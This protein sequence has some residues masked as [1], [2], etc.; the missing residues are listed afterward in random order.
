MPSPRVQQQIDRLLDEAEQAMADTD[1][2][3]VRKRCEAAL[4]LDP[5]NEDAQFYIDAADRAEGKSPAPT[6]DEQVTAAPSSPAERTTADASEIT[7]FADG[8]YEVT[9]FL[10]EGGRKIVYLAKDTLLDR[11]VA[12]ALI[13]TEGLDDAARERITREAQTM[14]RLGTHPNVVSVLDIG[15]HEGQPFV[16]IELLGGGDVEGL[17]E[18]AAG[19]LPLERTLEIAKDSARG[20]DFIHSKSIVHRDMKPGN[21]WLTADGVAKIGDYGLALSGNRTRLTLEGTMV[22]TVD[23]MPP[24]Q[25]LGGEITPRSDLYS[26]GAMIYELVTGTVPFKGDRITEVISQH[27]NT[28]PELPSLRGAKIPPALEELIL[29]LMAK[30]PDD[31]PESAAEVLQL[32]DTIDPSDTSQLDADYLAQ[33]AQGVFVGRSRELAEL[34]QRFDEA[35]SGISRLV[36]LVG[37]PGIGKTRLARELETH[38]RMR[39][40]RIYWGRAPEG[41]GAPPYWLFHQLL[42]GFLDANDELAARRDLGEEAPV[43]ARI[44]PDIATQL[45]GVSVDESAN[46]FA[47]HEA[48]RTFLNRLSRGTAL[49]VVLDDLH[50]AD[51]ES[52]AVLQHIS[53]DLEPTPLMFLGTYRDTET[54]RGDPLFEALATFNRE[55]SFVRL[56]VRGLDREG[57]AEFIERSAGFEPTREQLDL[58]IRETDGNPFFLSETVRSMLDAGTLDERAYELVTPD[59]VREALARRVNELDHDAVELLKLAAIVGYE[60]D[61]STLSIIS[62]FDEDRQLQLI[63]NALAERVIAEGESAGTYRFVY[64]PMQRLLLDEMAATRR[65]RLHG[66]IADRLAESYGSQADAHATVL[67]LHNAAAAEL[68][69]ERLDMALHFSEIA[70][71]QAESHND[72]LEAE[73]L[74]SRVLVLLERHSSSDDPRRATALSSLGRVEMRLGISFGDAKKH[75]SQAIDGFSA[76]RDVDSLVRAALDAF[77]LGNPRQTV[78]L[79][80]R[81]LRA[82]E[83]G[84]PVG[85]ARLL[86]W[87]AAGHGAGP[88]GNAAAERAETLA[89]QLDLPDVKGVLAYRKS[90]LAGAEGHLT[91]AVQRAEEALELLPNEEEQRRFIQSRL[92]EHSLQLGKLDEAIEMRRQQIVDAQNSPDVLRTS[93]AALGG[94][95]LLRWDLD[96]FDA[97]VDQPGRLHSGVDWRYAPLR[98]EMEGGLAGAYAMFS[99]GFERV[100]RSGYVAA[101][102]AATRSR[103]LLRMG[104]EEAA[105]S[106]FEDIDFGEDLSF[107]GLPA[108]ADEAFIKF[109]SRDVIR[110]WCERADRSDAWGPMRATRFGSFDRTRGTWWLSLGELDTAARFAEAGLSWTEAERCPIENGRCHYLLSEIH[111]ANGDSGGAAAHLDAAGDLFSRHGARLHLDQV[112]EQKDLLKA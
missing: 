10:G 84:D 76:N 58:F 13:K 71:L 29:R 49:L 47:I 85:E 52:L 69:P 61:F 67:A 2:V 101:V 72:W 31:R 7:S 73:R 38:A 81:A 96:S 8:R 105:R 30:D 54:N 53:R 51:A 82:V 46:E 106:A 40:A 95:L 25:A 35:V 21:V 16:V 3:V 6:G 98:R 109:S 74:Y 19:P 62:E 94:L 23:Y 12:F 112:L 93:E 1:W 44:A 111:Q 68:N 50:W 59:G 75:I 99:R 90:L 92:Y 70:G 22:G 17:L 80:E 64:E 83:G 108:V 42:R 102:G 91:E 57:I 88:S 37:Q 34:K 63:E 45:P 28:A 27:I 77:Y 65:L 66:Q 36:V 100:S 60:F 43:L 32:L 107:A 78:D 56:Q 103:M 48:M 110:E 87:I 24:E 9:R 4:A 33:L 11:D 14:G 79:A 18:D 55:P 89:E 39:G 104:D 26:L 15:E 86:A 20:L 41:G 5:Q 97:L